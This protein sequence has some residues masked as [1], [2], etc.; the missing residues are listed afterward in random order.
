MLFI[1]NLEVF[2]ARSLAK[3]PPFV[4]AGEKRIGI[5]RIIATH[6]EA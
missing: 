1:F 6:G 5:E 4:Q 3:L 2:T